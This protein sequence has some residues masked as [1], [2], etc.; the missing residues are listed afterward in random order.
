MPDQRKPIDRLLELPAIVRLAVVITALFLVAGPMVLLF[1]SPRWAALPEGEQRIVDATAALETARKRVARYQEIAG[2]TAVRDRFMEAFDA[3]IPARERMPEVL[4][5]A[6]LAA[7]K[8]GA[9]DLSFTRESEKAAD[10]S[11]AVVALKAESSGSH[12]AVKD[13][14]V[15]VE[16]RTDLRSAATFV[17]ALF[18]ASRYLRLEALDL[19]PLPPE[20]LTHIKPS[21]PARL[22]LILRFTTFSRQ[23]G[24]S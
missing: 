6:A 17:D 23:D 8:A 21:D 4:S 10:G 5:V 24:G 13:W 12:G 9:V 16:A 19:R 15:R 2:E 11:G 20:R 14:P 1:L 3:W 7:R 22:L 18:S